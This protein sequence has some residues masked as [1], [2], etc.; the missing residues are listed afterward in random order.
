MAFLGGACCAL[1]D[2]CGR[3]EPPR[4]DAHEALEVTGELAL[5]REAA[6]G[7]DRRL[8]GVVAS[9]Q[10]LLSS[11]DAGQDDVLVR[12]RPSSMQG[13]CGSRAETNFPYWSPAQRLVL[14]RYFS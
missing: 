8:G 6:A 7:G 12:P 1:G 13:G 4:R 2:S 3:P 9:F 11:L 10:E 14:Q 5:V